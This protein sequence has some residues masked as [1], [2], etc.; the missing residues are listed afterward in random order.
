MDPV[1]QPAAPNFSRYDRIPVVSTIT[2]LYC[3]YVKLRIVLNTP[4]SSLSKRNISYYKNKSILRCLV[5]L[6]PVIGNLAI[7]IYDKRILKQTDSDLNSDAEA[8]FVP[9]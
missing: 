6:L 4:P 3:F 1:N 8:D 7:Y 5:L 9:I 2:S